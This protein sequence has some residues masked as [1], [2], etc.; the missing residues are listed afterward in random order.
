MK[1]HQAVQELLSLAA[2]GVLNPKE[3]QRVQEHLR[4]CVICRAE[5]DDWQQI[6]HELRIL[7]TPQAPAGLLLRTQRLIQSHQFQ[8]A[9]NPGRLLL[10]CLLLVF[11]WVS[12]FLN[13]HL[14]RLI[15]LPLA[16]WLDISTTAIWISYIGISWLVAALSA[17]I[18]ARHLHREG[19]TV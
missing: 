3:Q 1:D 5:F 14:L 16:K 12:L 8:A 19:K 17:G 10:P 15:D 13:Y 7:P 6:T 4:Q 18:L 2:A 9:N 11:S